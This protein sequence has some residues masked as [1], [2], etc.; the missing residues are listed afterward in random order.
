MQNRK[1]N[2]GGWGLK[3]EEEKKWSKMQK[4]TTKEIQIKSE[5]NHQKIKDI[6]FR[7][8]TQISNV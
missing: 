8:Q 4:W 3:E 1:K 5:Q 2:P 7:D 6:L